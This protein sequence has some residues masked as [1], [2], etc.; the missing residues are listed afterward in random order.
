VFKK[1]YETKT[2]HRKL[3]WI[4]GLGTCNLNG[5]FQPRSI[6]LQ[7]SAFQAATLLLFNDDDKLTVEEIRE[8]LQLPQEDLYRALHSL[9][10]GKYKILLKEPAGKTVSARWFDLIDS[11]CCVRKELLRKYSCMACCIGLRRY[12]CENL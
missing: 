6:E 2:K 11:S 3:T 12:S 9:T 1:F 8:R 4:Y 10:C 5:K 7:L